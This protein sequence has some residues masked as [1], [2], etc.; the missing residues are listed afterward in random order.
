[1]GTTIPTSKLGFHAVVPTGNMF[2]IPPDDHAVK[3][4]PKG[5]PRHRQEMVYLIT[6]IPAVPSLPAYATVAMDAIP[7]WLLNKL[8]LR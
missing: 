6:A 1:M 2:A 3:E 5:S 4:H 7:N 8:G